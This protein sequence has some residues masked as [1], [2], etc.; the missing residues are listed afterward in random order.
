MD[1]KKSAYLSFRTTPEVKEILDTEAKELDR[2][3]SW[4]LN[5]IVTEYVNQKNLPTKNVQFNINHNENIN[6]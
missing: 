2:P 1:D 4:L 6:L 5:K 3:I